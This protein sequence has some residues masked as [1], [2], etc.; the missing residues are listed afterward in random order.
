MKPW[1]ELRAE[2]VEDFEDQSRRLLVFAM[3]IMYGNEHEAFCLDDMLEE[4][5]L[6]AIGEPV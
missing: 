3:H 6:N 1:Y 2:E 5:H 4:A